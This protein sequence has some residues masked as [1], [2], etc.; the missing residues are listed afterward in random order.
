ML[1][2]AGEVPGQSKQKFMASGTYGCTPEEKLQIEHTF[3]S[4]LSVTH[5][6]QKPLNGAKVT[7]IVCLQDIVGTGATGVILS[8]VALT[9]PGNGRH[10]VSLFAPDVNAAVNGPLAAANELKTV[11]GAAVLVLLCMSR[12]LGFAD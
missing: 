10:P 12:V 11:S 6:F 9:A 7:V 3:L 8:P 2:R 1:I 4:A 5:V